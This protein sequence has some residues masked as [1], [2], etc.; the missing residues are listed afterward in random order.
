MSSPGDATD[1]FG[2]GTLVAST[3]AGFS[4]DGNTPAILGF[5]T[6]RDGTG[7]G[8]T[9][10]GARYHGTA[11]QAKIMGYKVCGPAPITSVNVP[12]SGQAVFYVRVQTQSVSSET[13]FQWFVKATHAATGQELRMPFYFRAIGSAVGGVVAPVQNTPTNVEL[14]ATM[15][16][17]TDLNGMYTLNWSYMTPAGGL[18]PIGYRIQ[19]GASSASVFFDNADTPLA[20]GAN[21]TWSGSAQWT[22]QPNP[23]S[24]NVPP[25]NL[26]YFVPNAANQNESL[27]MINQ[28]SLAGATGA[29][30]SFVTNQDTEPDFDFINVEISNNNG[31]SWTTLASYTGNLVGVRE[32]DISA[33]AGQNVR[34]RFRMVS[35]LAVPALGTYIEDIRITT[36]DFTTIADIGPNP[37]IY[38]V[39]LRTNGTRNYRIAARFNTDNG[40]IAGPFSNVRCVTTAQ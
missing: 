40:Q 27:A 39:P 33:F 2:H 32:I 16:C 30:L 18:T 8:P 9:L 15:P 24:P 38:N 37:L 21:V 36:N 3:A 31:T 28:I 19:E 4:V 6:G 29:S 20:N 5:G 34:V 13:E 12:S 11:P 17:P 1:D 22:T 7:I 25:G 26:S 14:S 10:T 35:D 23:T